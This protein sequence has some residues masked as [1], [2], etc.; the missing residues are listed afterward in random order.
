M[1][2][3]KTDPSSCGLSWTKVPNLE[4]LPG[5]PYPKDVAHGSHVFS[6]AKIDIA[7][8]ETYM[9]KGDE[10]HF[11][12]DAD[13]T[14]YLRDTDVEIPCNKCIAFGNGQLFRGG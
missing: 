4:C 2:C 5:C 6:P 12:C 1:N 8:V 11:S 13:Y 3:E 14:A 10:A 9:K 7:N